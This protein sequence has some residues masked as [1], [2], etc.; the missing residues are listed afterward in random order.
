MIDENLHPEIQAMLELKLDPLYQF[1]GSFTTAKRLRQYRN[2][3]GLL[4]ETLASRFSAPSKGPS[5]SLMQ[6][7]RHTK[8]RFDKE[9]QES[10]SISHRPHST[11]ISSPLYTETGTIDHSPLSVRAPSYTYT[12]NEIHVQDD[13]DDKLSFGGNKKTPKFSGEPEKKFWMPKLSLDSQNR[14]ASKTRSFKKISQPSSTNNRSISPQEINQG[15]TTAHSL[16]GEGSTRHAM[17]VLDILQKTPEEKKKK[18]DQSYLALIAL[19]S[20]HLQHQDQGRL[21]S[22]NRQNYQGKTREF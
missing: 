8:P 15:S 9:Y 6:G 21:H 18:L 14:P 16:I 11:N 17:T 4:E 1:I 20:T 13:E 19:I 3:P 12:E 5:Q 10:G 7:L 22:K 2:K